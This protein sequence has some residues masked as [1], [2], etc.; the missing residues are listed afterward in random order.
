MTTPV[1]GVGGRLAAIACAIF[2]PELR[3]WSQ[4]IPQLGRIELVRQDLHN[5]PR[6]LQAELVRVLARVEDDAQVGA[7]ALVYGL[8]SRAVDGLAPRRVPVAIPR[9]HDCITLYLGSHA[10]YDEQMRRHPG[11]YWYT[12]G[13]SEVHRTPTG[14]SRDRILAELIEKYGEDNGPYI[15]ETLHQSWMDNYSRAAYTDLGIGDVAQAE[16]VARRLADERGWSYEKLPGDPGLLLRL[17]RGDWDG[18][19]IVVVR[20]GQRL[21]MTGDQRI[22]EAVAT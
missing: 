21:R 13:W 20:P 22:L 9:V 5:T 8:C 1:A 19:D 18:D 2:E 16:G 14:E 11:T 15:F 4:A 12:P 6:D 3:A 7:V 10:R 17:L